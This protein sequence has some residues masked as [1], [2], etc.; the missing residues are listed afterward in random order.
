MKQKNGFLLFTDLLLGLSLLVL[1]LGLAFSVFHYQEKK[2]AVDLT[3]R[4]L[5]MELQYIR[6]LHVGNNGGILYLYLDENGYKIIR[7]INILKT[8]T[9]SPLVRGT[10]GE[11]TFD[12]KGKPKK[13][14]SLSF[15]SADGTYERHIVLA[16]QTGRIR[17]E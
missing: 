9:Y 12:V 7:G 1:F 17:L 10:K 11:V 13:D 6:Q 2:Q 4:E 5:A 16:A 3:V 14:M 15:S 8:Y